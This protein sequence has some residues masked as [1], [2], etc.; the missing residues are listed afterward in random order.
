MFNTFFM[1]N[2]VDCLKQKK[3]IV[4][5]ISMLLLSNKEIAGSYV[6]QTIFSICI[7]FIHEIPENRSLGIYFDRKVWQTDGRQSDAK[8]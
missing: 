3:I 5:M 6:L 7:I 1:T 4:Q 8:V 2:I